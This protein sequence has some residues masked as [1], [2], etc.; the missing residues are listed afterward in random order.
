MTSLMPQKAFLGD[1]QRLLA[2]IGKACIFLYKMDMQTIIVHPS[3]IFVTDVSHS[4]LAHLQPP[5]LGKGY[6]RLNDEMFIPARIDVLKSWRDAISVPG[7]VEVNPTSIVYEQE[8]HHLSR[9]LT[10]GEKHTVWVE[11]PL[12]DVLYPSVEVLLLMFRFELLKNGWIRVRFKE[13]DWQV[14]AVFT[15]GKR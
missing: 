8:G 5:E 12:M 11:K 3:A 9:K 7:L 10:D 2:Y 15:P 6:L 1:P 14:V 13:H 4:K